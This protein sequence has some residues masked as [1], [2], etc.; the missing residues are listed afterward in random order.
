VTLSAGDS[1]Y[2]SRRF[3]RRLIP[4]FA[5]CMPAIRELLK[6]IPK[7][8]I[9]IPEFEKTHYPDVFARERLAQKLDLPEARIQVCETRPFNDQSINQS[10]NQSIKGMVLQPPGQVAA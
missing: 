10:I 2:V 8:I 3:D 4:L 6:R 1:L 5:I 9:L 7:K